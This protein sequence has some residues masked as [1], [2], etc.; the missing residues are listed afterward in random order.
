MGGMRCRGFFKKSWPDKPLI[1]IIIPVLNRVGVLDEAL[2]SVLHQKYENVELVVIDGGSTDGTLELIRKYDACIDIWSSQ[3]DNG[4]Y[5]AMNKGARLAG[6]DWLYFLG[7]DDVVLNV[8]HRVA[9][10]L[11]K[12]NEVYYGDVY[13]PTMH[14]IY[15]GRFTPY[16]LMKNNIPHQATFYPKALFLKHSYELKYK[17]AGDYF[18]NITCYNDRDFAYVYIPVLVAIFDDTG[19]VSAIDGDPEFDQDFNSILKEHFGRFK[20]CQF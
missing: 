17:S 2:R 3:P 20:Y 5:D 6:G 13:L 10:F 4:I 14:R 19:G 16:R 15:D 11:R 18:F 7:S 9:Y 8:L 12:E 1:S